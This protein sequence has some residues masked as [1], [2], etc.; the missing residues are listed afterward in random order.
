MFLSNNKRSEL[1]IYYQR[2][3]N[4]NEDK[5]CKLLDIKLSKNQQRKILKCTNSYC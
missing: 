2:G 4:I 1:V 5:T 3:N